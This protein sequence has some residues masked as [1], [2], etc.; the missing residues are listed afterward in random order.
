MIRKSALLKLLTAVFCLFILFS[1]SSC[2]SNQNYLDRGGKSNYSKVRSHQPSWN[3]STAPRTRYQLKKK[4]NK[5]SAR[6]KHKGKAASTR[7]RIYSIL[8]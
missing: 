3:S 7:S 2:S 8:K 6:K 1:L 4:K 5:Q